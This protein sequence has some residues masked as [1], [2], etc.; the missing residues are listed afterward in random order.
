MRSMRSVV[1]TMPPR[2]GRLPP[3]KP[4]PAPRGKTGIFSALAIFITRLISALVPGWTTTSGRK[5]CWVAS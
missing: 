3:V 4:L 1:S 5:R 2:V